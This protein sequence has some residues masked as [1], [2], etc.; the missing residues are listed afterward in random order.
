MPSL[1]LE[2]PFSSYCAYPNLSHA[3]MSRPPGPESLSNQARVR[4]WLVS[5]MWH[6]KLILA[7]HYG[8]NMSYLSYQV[9]ST[10]RIET[11]HVCSFNHTLN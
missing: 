8:F 7:Y 2:T 3:P 5:L 10:M 1:Y 9:I 11:V 6:L 4:V